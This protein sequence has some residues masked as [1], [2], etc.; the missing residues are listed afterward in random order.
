MLHCFPLFCCL[1]LFVFFIEYIDLAIDHHILFVSN[2]IH[3]YLFCQMMNSDRSVFLFQ[4]KK[5]QGSSLAIW[6]YRCPSSCDHW[7]EERHSES[8]HASLRLWGWDL[9]SGP[10][11]VLQEVP[12]ARRVGA[13]QCLCA[14]AGELN[15]RTFRKPT[16]H[17]QSYC[18]PSL[19]FKVSHAAA[20]PQDIRF[21]WCVK[22]WIVREIKSNALLLLSLT[23]KRNPYICVLFVVWI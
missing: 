1:F 14:T 17:N 18:L 20:C 9:P 5:A 4:V 19:H 8:G 3:I 12:A 2:N 11:W 10:V 21:F 16:R 6:K 22:M 7:A 23:P 15:G 13:G